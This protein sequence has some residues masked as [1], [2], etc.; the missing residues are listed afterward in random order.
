MSCQHTKRRP[1]NMNSTSMVQGKG[2]QTVRSLQHCW[3]S[4]LGVVLGS[5]LGL[6]VRLG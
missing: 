3:G 5:V 4:L 1:T 6:V 2:G